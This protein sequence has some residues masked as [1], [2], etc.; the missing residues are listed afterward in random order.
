VPIKSRLLPNALLIVEI[1]TWTL[2]G[3][4]CQV[5]RVGISSLGP[6]HQPVSSAAPSDILVMHPHADSLHE[7]PNEWPSAPREG[8][9][10]S[11]PGKR[12]TIRQFCEKA[13]AR[14]HIISGLFRRQLGHFTPIGWIVRS[15]DGSDI[16]SSVVTGPT[17][18]NC[19]REGHADRLKPLL[20]TVPVTV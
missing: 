7:A 1:W 12:A 14:M 16:D 15:E 20:K 19:E 2:L 5:A 8:N 13:T 4:P 6:V 17:C 10:R 9:N 3:P 18:S 11:M